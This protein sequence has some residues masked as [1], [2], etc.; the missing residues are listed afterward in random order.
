MNNNPAGMAVTR[1]LTVCSVAPWPARIGAVCQCQACRAWRR[2]GCRAGAAAEH[3]TLAPPVATCPQHSTATTPRFTN[4]RQHQSDHNKGTCVIAA[5]YHVV[6]TTYASKVCL[7]SFVYISSTYM[8]RLKQQHFNSTLKI[9]V[10]SY[11]VKLKI[12]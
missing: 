10:R 11:V 1:P 2:Q 7:V 4:I 5:R 6:L 12:P 9:H 3:L 8:W